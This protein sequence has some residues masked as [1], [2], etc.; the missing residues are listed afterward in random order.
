MES[1]LLSSECYRAFRL[2]IVPNEPSI[3]AVQG[4][5][6]NPEKS[7][8]WKAQSKEDKYAVK[9][10]DKCEPVDW[11]KELLPVD[12]PNARIMAF[13]YESRWRGNAPHQHIGTCA[14]RL[15]DS[16]RNPGLQVIQAA[17]HLLFFQ[18]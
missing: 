5:A 8:I 16:L 9:F 15:L 11:L 3:I 7:W 17:L 6:S 18:N 10:G 14:T 2:E 1:I 4:L 13:N 12:L